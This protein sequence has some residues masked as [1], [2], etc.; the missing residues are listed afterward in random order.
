MIAKKFLKLS[1][2]YQFS[3]KVRWKVVSILPVIAISEMKGSSS[4][5]HD[6]T[7]KHSSFHPAVFPGF[8]RLLLRHL[9]R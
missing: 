3:L 1:V 6:E 7:G 5:Q 4:P 8:Q 9:E 2:L